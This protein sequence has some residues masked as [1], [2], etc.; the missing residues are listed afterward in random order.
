MRSLASFGDHGVCRDDDT[1]RRTEHFFF[2]LGKGTDLSF[3]DVG[4]VKELL[5]PLGYRYT[6]VTREKTSE[7]VCTTKKKGNQTNAEV[8]STSALF[9]IVQ[10]A[11]IP[12][13]VFPAPQGK[14]MIP[15]L[16]LPLPN[17]LA[18]LIS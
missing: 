11:V 3:R 8:Q 12:T 6:T 4:E 15:D 17:I 7:N 9:L 14:T 2:T 5:F 18:R 13:S 10:A 16:A 1:R